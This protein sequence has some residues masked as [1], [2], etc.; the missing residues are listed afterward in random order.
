MAFLSPC[1]LPLLPVYVTYFAAG[2]TN[3]KRTRNNA[4]GFFVGLTVVFIALGVFAGAIGAQLSGRR[5]EIIAG[6][7]IILFGLHYLGV[8]TLP[9]R[10]GRGVSAARLKSLNTPWSVVF[11]ATFALCWTP[12]VGPFLGAALMKAAIAGTVAEGALLLFVFALGL[13]IPFFLSALLLD[14]FKGVFGWIKRH[15]GVI[16]KVCGVFLIGMGILML[17][18]LFSQWAHT[19][20]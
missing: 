6:A 16:N 11:G 9:G 15:H 20:L 10:A 2:E 3:G 5:M 14:H 8:F 18:G 1:V 12:C 13:G 4:I 19:L 17:L 7:L